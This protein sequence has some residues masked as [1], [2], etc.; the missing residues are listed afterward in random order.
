MFELGLG[1]GRPA[2][3]WGLL[4]QTGVGQMTGWEVTQ[5]EVLGVLEFV[6]GE[7][8]WPLRHCRQARNPSCPW[9]TRNS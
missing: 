7:A 3:T 1:P 2:L 4:D 8:I 9:L 6:V 5:E